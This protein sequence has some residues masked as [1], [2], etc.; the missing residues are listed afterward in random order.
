[1]SMKKK[2]QDHNL[3]APIT[4]AADNKRFNIIL[5]FCV[6]QSLTFHV[7]YLWQYLVLF[8]FLEQGQILKMSS[9]ANF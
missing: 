3:K 4:T 9:A 6:K 5:E 2:L 8:G 1:M 7:N